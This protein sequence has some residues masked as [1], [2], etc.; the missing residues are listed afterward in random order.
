[1]KDPVEFPANNVY[2][3][4]PFDTSLR[5]TWLRKNA[6]PVDDSSRGASAN[7]VKDTE[8]G[9]AGIFTG[10]FDFAPTTVLPSALRSE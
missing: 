2:R 7:E 9:V 8:V 6:L 1:M 4:L 10:F 3:V 5:M